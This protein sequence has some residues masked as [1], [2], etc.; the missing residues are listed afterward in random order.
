MQRQQR[1]CWPTLSRRIVRANRESGKQRV[2]TA[3]PMRILERMA[4]RTLCLAADETL[5]AVDFE[6]VVAVVAYFSQVEQR[7][8]DTGQHASH[9]VSG[10]TLWRGDAGCALG[11]AALHARLPNAA[12]VFAPQ[13]CVQGGEYVLRVGKMEAEAACERHVV[14]AGLKRLNGALQY[15][16]LQGRISSTGATDSAPAAPATRVKWTCND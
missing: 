7:L 3:A 16:G 2:S 8:H 14:F 11:F 13:F 6:A 1:C 12:F 10:K 5:Q 9:S 15:R 4:L